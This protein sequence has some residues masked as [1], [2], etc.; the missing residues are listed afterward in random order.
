[1]APWNVTHVCSAW[2]QA[3]VE[4]PNLWNNVAVTFRID[5]EEEC[6]LLKSIL[7][8]FLSRTGESLISLKIIAKNLLDSHS[9]CGSIIDLLLPYIGRFRHLSLHPCEALCSLL[10]SK[11][12]ALESAELDFSE[13][14]NPD[15]DVFNTIFLDKT[16]NLRRVTISS[17]FLDLDLDPFHISWANLTQLCLKNTYLAYS[18][19]HAVLRQCVRLVSLAFGIVP[20]IECRGM[21]RNTILPVLESLKVAIYT[22]EQCGQFLQPF[23]LP[24][25]KRLE[26]DSIS[27][28]SQ[29]SEMILP[30]LVQRSSC[31]LRRFEASAL[32]PSTVT[33]FLMTVPSLTRLILHNLRVG[34]LREPIQDKDMFSAIARGSLVPNL[35]HF[36]CRLYDLEYVINSVERRTNTATSRISPCTP[37]RSMVIHGYPGNKWQGVQERLSRLRAQGTN[38]I[39]RDTS[40]DIVKI[41]HNHVRNIH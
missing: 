40:L 11:V 16:C 13:A 19:G 25:L 21:T 10:E 18:Q 4:M 8:A 17:N 20:D 38:I 22:G 37:I 24:S 3:A 9:F 12:N 2:R 26:I 32:A 1:M 27:T 23:I 39:F 6:A 29:W 7:E 15:H 31:Q 30:Q 33:A 14:F 35:Q 34:R 5:M 36:E 28:C 41:S